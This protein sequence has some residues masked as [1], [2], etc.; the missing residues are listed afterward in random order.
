MK[1]SVHGLILQSELELTPL[2]PVETDRQEHAVIAYKKVGALGIS[3]PRKIRPFSQISEGRIWMDI[4]DIA[5]YEITNGNTIKVDP[6]PRADKKSVRLYLMGSAMG[7]LLHQRG[8]LVLHANAI[9]VGNGVVV[10]AGISGAGKSTTAAEFH[11][12][13]YEVITDD[14]LAVN[15]QG[16]ASGGFPQIKLWEDALQQLNIEKQDLRR[17]RKQINKY[18]FPI[19]PTYCDQNQPINAIYILQVSNEQNSADVEFIKLEGIEK[20]NVLKNYTYRRRMMEGLK[21]QASHLKLCGTLA[22]SM[23]M[24]RLIR[25]AIGFSVT[26]L[27]DAVLDDLV[28]L[29]L[30]TS[31]RIENRT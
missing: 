2:L 9:K 4:P 23:P 16:T 26:Q 1:Y 7:A 8:Y 27:V 18:S 15:S 21:L 13:G 3:E 14:V 30:H 25:P 10:F 12:R 24:S 28:S 6:Y 11:K 17:V 20:F 29:G 5:R 19:E 22:A 31:T